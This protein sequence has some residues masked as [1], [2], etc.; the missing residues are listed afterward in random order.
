MFCKSWAA[1]FRTMFTENW[2]YLTNAKNFNKRLT[3]WKIENIKYISTSFFEQQTNAHVLD[4]LNNVYWYNTRITCSR[5]NKK[6]RN[7]L[8][9]YIN[10]AFLFQFQFALL[11]IIIAANR[12]RTTEQ[13]DTDPIRQEEQK[14]LPVG[15]YVCVL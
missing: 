2:K 10:F 3:M 12:R 8:L 7:L 1:K 15:E 5:I 4:T 6:L 11:I 9:F 14:L 13:K